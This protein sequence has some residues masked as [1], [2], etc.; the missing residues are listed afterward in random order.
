MRWLISSGGHSI[1]ALTFFFAL[2]LLFQ[3]GLKRLL[4]ASCRW[5]LHLPQCPVLGIIWRL[6]FTWSAWKEDV[7][8]FSL[9]LLIYID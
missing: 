5:N 3:I 9:I 7:L 2:C 4:A 1:G 8:C 6:K